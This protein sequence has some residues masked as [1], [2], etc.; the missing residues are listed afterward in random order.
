MRLRDSGS[1]M[2]QPGSFYAGDGW[3]SFNSIMR[4][5]T[6]LLASFAIIFWAFPLVDRSISPQSTRVNERQTRS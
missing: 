6:G 2:F 4:L 3:G 5:I 1:L